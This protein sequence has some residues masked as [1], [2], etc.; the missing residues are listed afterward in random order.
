MLVGLEGRAPVRFRSEHGGWVNSIEL[1]HV[2]SPLGLVAWQL[3]QHADGRLSLTMHDAGAP[4][5]AL[6]EAA[7]RSLLGTVPLEV[8]TAD[9][10]GDAKPQRYSSDLPSAVIP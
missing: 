1:T 9:L 3:H 6:A 5:P 7:V 10:A 8:R 4:L 2:L